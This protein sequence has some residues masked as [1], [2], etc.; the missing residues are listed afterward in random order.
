MKSLINWIAARAKE[1]STWAG[2][3]A[4][5]AAVAPVADAYAQGGKTAAIG[6][7]LTAIL[8][9]TMKEGSK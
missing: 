8:A 7:A 5:T 9:V 2:I 1:P 3:S 6:A 4:A